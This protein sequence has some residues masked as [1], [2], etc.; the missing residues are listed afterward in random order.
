V[1]TSG[2][3]AQAFP[4]SSGHR[5]GA[6]RDETTGSSPLGWRIFSLRNV[7]SFLLALVALYLVY[8]QLLGL[9]WGEVWA[10]VRGAKA[11][12]FAL[13]FLAFYCSFPLRAL[14]WKTL[15][16]NIGYGTVVGRPIPS[17]LGL[18]RIM[19][20]AWFANCL[21]I[22]RFGDAYRGYLLKKVT[23]ISF[24]AT[25]GTVLTERFLDLVV[26]VAVVGAGVLVVFGGT[27][28]AAATQ[29]LTAGLILSAV[30]V[31][32]LLTM[33]R[34]RGVLERL[35]P[36]RFRAHYSSLTHGLVDS[37]RHLPLLVAYSALGWMLEGLTLYTTAAAVGTRVS[38]AGALVVALVGSLLTTVPFTPAGLGFTE[39]GLVLLLGWLGVDV[40]TASAV[41]LLFRLINYWSI[42]VFGFILYVFSRN[43]NQLKGMPAVPM[44]IRRSLIGRS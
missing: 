17:V 2:R 14:R 41:T 28:P 34:F 11:W 37:F 6:L 32:G 21:T 43:T 5:S 16:N 35:V 19:Y 1:I 13:A 38:I 20:L 22:A 8:R 39:A 31:V 36:K 30:G 23:G 12:L 3:R 44:R 4:E 27:L 24:A 10:S 26:L 33:R 15:L 9:D 7:G 42:V 18:T 40:P 25:L 29:A